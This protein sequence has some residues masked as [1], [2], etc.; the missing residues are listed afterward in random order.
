MRKCLTAL[1]AVVFTFCFT[2]VVSAEV[3]SPAGVQ[4]PALNM[5]PVQQEIQSNSAYNDELSRD[6][7]T[8]FKHFIPSYYY[9]EIVDMNRCV[10]QVLEKGLEACLDKNSH[11]MMA[12]QYKAQV[13]RI[14]DKGFGG[15]GFSMVLVD[16]KIAIFDFEMFEDSPAEKAGLKEGD[17]LVGVESDGKVES[18]VGK[19]LK[20]AVLLIRGK[21][22]T[23]VKIMVIRG[24]EQKEFE[25]K[26]AQIKIRHVKYA[27]EPGLKCDSLSGVSG[28]IGYVKIYDFMS[29]NVAAQFE[30]ALDE[31]AAQGVTCFAL[32]VRN[33]AGGLLGEV[34]RM[35]TLFESDPDAIIVTQ[36]IRYATGSPEDQHW[37]ARAASR[38]FGKYKD[39]RVVVLQ[40]KNSASASEIFAAYLKFKG[41][42]VVGETSYKK[43]TVQAD[44]VLPSGGSLHLTI[45]EYFVSKAR[46]KVNEV[47]VEPDYEVKNGEDWSGRRFD[48]LQFSKAL[49]ILAS[50]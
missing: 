15:V 18:L 37:L 9:L 43:G 19:S 30:N 6:F 33:N 40:N 25:M 47:G 8:I 17:V 5:T 13:E 49:Q 42:K 39:M 11:Y 20:E 21:I 38:T 27:L 36:H 34:A 16:G 3:T 26:R 32:D 2:A 29:Q 14:E 22:G 45:A 48:D 24:T 28:K 7:H 4:I 35:L 46:I 12:E 10:A 31:L 41:A 44:L 50:H 1:F 23:F